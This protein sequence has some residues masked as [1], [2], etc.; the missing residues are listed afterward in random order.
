[1][2]RIHL[3]LIGLVVA[4]GCQSSHWPL[5]AAK[6]PNLPSPWLTVQKAEAAEAAESVQ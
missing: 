3:L 2:T 6:K 4:T 1:M 5:A